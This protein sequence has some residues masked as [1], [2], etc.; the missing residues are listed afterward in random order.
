MKE[1]WVA[2]R[3]AVHVPGHPYANNRGYV[4]RSRYVMEQVL[5]RYLKSSEHVHHI[6][7]NQEDDRP[8]NLEL[9]TRSKHAREHWRRGDLK[10][11]LDYCWIAALRTDGLGYKRIATI[12][13]YPRSSIRSACRL[14]GV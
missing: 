7:G 3:M 1:S 12:T 4:L 5:G 2:G 9:T 13:G 8:E 6:N 14:M 11:K 10:R